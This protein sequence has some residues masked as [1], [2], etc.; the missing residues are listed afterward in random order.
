MAI[1]L[2]WSNLLKL[3]ELDFLPEP[4]GDLQVADEIIQTI[5]WLTIATSHDRRLVR[6]NELGAVLVGNAWDNLSVV[7][8]DELI[9]ASTVADVFTATLPN[10]GVLVTT[11]TQIVKVTFVRVAGGA[12]EAIY[13]PPGGLYFYPHTT[14]SVT[15]NVVPD[16][17]G[18]TSYIGITAYN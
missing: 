9:P 11:S 12:T 4:S 14:Y 6:G 18:T 1:K 8:T 7:E 16:P 2:R 13:L 15:V 17:G 3:T 10:R 5:S